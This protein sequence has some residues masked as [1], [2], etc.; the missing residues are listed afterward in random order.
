MFLAALSLLILAA[1]WLLVR[2]SALRRLAD[3]PPQTHAPAADEELQLDALC[4]RAGPAANRAMLRRFLRARGELEPALAGY[5]ECVEWR[6]ANDVDRYGGLR[7]IVSGA[8][9]QER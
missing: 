3:A 5:R 4:A 1:A 6:K 2:V 8:P 9:S 7:R